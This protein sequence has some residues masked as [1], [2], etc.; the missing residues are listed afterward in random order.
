MP[1]PD[2]LREMYARHDGATLEGDGHQ[3]LFLFPMW[4]EWMPL[5]DVVAQA[6]FAL[7]WMKQYGVNA[8]PFALHGTGQFM[9]CEADGDERVWK[10][11][12][13]PPTPAWPDGTVDGLLRA[14]CDA[15]RGQS[16][17]YRVEFSEDR[18]GWT[19]SWQPNW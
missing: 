2:F 7:L 15:Y 6:E 1:V 14:T 3:G 5:E 17:E 4:W 19:A 9:A 10:I 18:M 8:F 12:E 16:D 13:E 11:D